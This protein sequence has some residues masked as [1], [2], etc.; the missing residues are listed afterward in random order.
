M[1]GTFKRHALLLSLLLA[2]LTGAGAALVTARPFA[3]AASAGSLPAFGSEARF[4]AF[5]RERRAIVEPMMRAREGSSPSLNMMM[6]ALEAAA[7]DASGDESIT[8]VQEAGVDE[9]G[10]VK[11][12]GDYL[13]VLRRGRLFTLSLAGGLKAVDSIDVPPPGTPAPRTDWGGA[14][15]DEMLV[16]GDHIAVI[17][18][19][20]ETQ[21]TQI[22]RFRL[23][24]GGELSFQ[25]VYRLRASDYYSAE[26]YA[27]RLIGEQLVL[28]NVRPLWDVGDPMDVLP[29]LVDE[30]PGRARTTQVLT[31]PEEVFLDRN[32][33]PSTLDFDALHSVTRCDLTAPRLD[34]GAT[35]VLGPTSRTFY[36]STEAIYLW[37][38]ARADRPGGSGR[39]PATVYRMPLD[40][41]RPQAVGASGAPLDQFSFREDRRAGR[42]DVVVMSDGGGDAM[43]DRERRDGS[44]ALLSLPLSRF[45]DGSGAAL[46]GDYC[47]LRGVPEGG[48][49]RE[50]RFVGDHL[51]YAV[52]R[53]SDWR[54][55][56]DG[57]G[58]VLLAM[59]IDSGESTILELPDPVTRIEALGPD[60]LVATGGRHGMVVTAVELDGRR[61][62]PGARYSVPNAGE[63][64]GRSHGFFYRADGP[65]GEAGLLGLPIQRYPPPDSRHTEW[66]GGVD[67]LFMRR[68]PDSL[69]SLGALSTAGVDRPDFCHVSC[70]DW[71][72]A[73][74]PIFLR[75]RIFALM[76]YELIE[77][78][79]EVGRI[80]EI[81]RLDFTPRRNAAA[82]LAPAA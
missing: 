15:Y 13:V 58:G 22:L 41:G 78:R 37:T 12:A 29:T 52:E 49:R 39:P 47:P 38:T 27:S 9:G 25:D 48:W 68:R 7:A 64:E 36:V 56:G 82:R 66:A 81:A 53:A 77:G 16:V 59:R 32:A 51:L 20:Y 63:S 44:V 34:C 72:G 10:I 54:I 23:S 55:S 40:G 57:P 80:R 2:V 67:M 76:G 31:R 61:T 45:G 71:Y 18:Y 74:R 28:Y 19:S 11:A 42:L 70:V 4:R 73:S 35:A 50:N 14:W 43:W 33:R 8:N 6:P 62:A 21:G 26:N 75:G 24:P 46:A 3:P 1:P 17:G 65:G 69:T 60:A 30:T 79:E 5:F